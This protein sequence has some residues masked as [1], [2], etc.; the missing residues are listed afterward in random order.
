M[1]CNYEKKW[2]K[3]SVKARSEFIEEAYEKTHKYSATKTKM[4]NWWHNL[5]D[6]KRTEFVKRYFK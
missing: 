4:S 2:S 5:S 6:K 3:M 1:G